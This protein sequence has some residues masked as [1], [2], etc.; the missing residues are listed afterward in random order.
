MGPPSRRPLE[1]CPKK[2]RGPSRFGRD[3]T[4][5]LICLAARSIPKIQQ[6]TRIS[7]LYFLFGTTAPAENSRQL[8]LLVCLGGAHER[9]S[10]SP[11]R[12]DCQ[13]RARENCRYV[14]FLQGTPLRRC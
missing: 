12:R 3:R 5:E 6:I 2:S 7:K 8:S 1:P 13:E 10:R 4:P 9:G 11:H 14:A